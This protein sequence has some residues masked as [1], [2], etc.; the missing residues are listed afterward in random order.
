[1]I[2]LE[3]LDLLSK[4]IIHT[5]IVLINLI[6]AIFL[7]QLCKNFSK[8]K[9]KIEPV[10]VGYF[11]TSLFLYYIPFEFANIIAYSI[12]LFVSFLIY[13]YLDKRNVHMKIFLIITFFS[14]RW[15]SATFGNLSVTSVFKIIELT[16]FKNFEI[17][18]TQTLI[19]AYIEIILQ[20]VLYLAVFAILLYFFT[21]IIQNKFKNK[22]NDI[23]LKEFLFLSI[24]AVGGIIWYQ[25]VQTY[26]NIFK[27]INGQSIYITNPHIQYVL[28]FGQIIIL[29]TIISTIILYQDNKNLEEKEREKIILKNEVN[30]IKSHILQVEK[31]YKEIR[32]IKH[33]I[34]NHISV[35]N[36]LLKQNKIPQLNQY[37][38]EMEKNVEDSSFTIKTGNPVTDI[39][40][41]ENMTK[42]TE[43][44]ITFKSE[45]HYL[46]SDKLS[47]FDVSV[48][49][50]NALSNAI[51]STKSGGYVNISSF[52][53]KN[54]YLITVENSFQGEILIDKENG[55]P[56]TNEKD[57]T[58]HGFGMKNMKNIAEKYFGSLIFEQ[59]EDKVILTVMMLV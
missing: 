39:I 15:I 57:K 40:I 4:I 19:Y 33:D 38:G 23:S 51:E 16:I 22:Y 42:A 44:G 30:D 36:S 3:K 50:S 2:E 5:E 20:T 7:T 46:D 13:M 21:R 35:I 1:M 6:T 47:S 28:M 9:H 53:N 27:Q 12:S 59:K 24:P 29:I 49:L 55:L 26:A 52:K 32:G 54:V 8:N 58:V 18:D 56:L 48:I 34:N 43:K 45:F 14:L 17:N 31:L 37:L 11:F 41:N 25:I 10:G